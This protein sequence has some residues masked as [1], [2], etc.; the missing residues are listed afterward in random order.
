[1][2]MKEREKEGV[3]EGSNV[4]VLIGKGENERMR[5]RK[6]GRKKQNNGGIQQLVGGSRRSSRFV[7]D[8]EWREKICS[9]CNL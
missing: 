9:I 4:I 7:I 1:M 2:D 6:R 3:F 8:G 5:W